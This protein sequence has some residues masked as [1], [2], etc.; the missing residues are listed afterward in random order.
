MSQGVSSISSR[1]PAAPRSAL[2]SPT[3]VTI[4]QSPPEQVLV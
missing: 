1:I 2:R 3:S 4:M